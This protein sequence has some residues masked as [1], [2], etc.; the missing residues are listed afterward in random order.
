MIYHEINNLFKCIFSLECIFGFVGLDKA[1][2][3]L[4]TG[5]LPTV[6]VL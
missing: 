3:H 6:P 1:F 2:Y 4:K 5:V